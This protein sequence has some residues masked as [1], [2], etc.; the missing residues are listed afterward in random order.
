MFGKYYCIYLQH[1]ASYLLY[2]ILY[3]WKGYGKYLC[4]TRQRKAY[5]VY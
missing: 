2:I 1:Y 4:C 3:K 5:K